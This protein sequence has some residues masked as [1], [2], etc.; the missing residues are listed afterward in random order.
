MAKYKI[1]NMDL[2]KYHEYMKW[3]FKTKYNLNKIS[4]IIF[5]PIEVVVY[6]YGNYYKLYDRAL[7]IDEIKCGLKRAYVVN[8]LIAIIEVK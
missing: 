6:L 2:M 5:S 1:K 3:N 7:D 8:K 4:D